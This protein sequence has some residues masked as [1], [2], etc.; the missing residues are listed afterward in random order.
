MLD[1]AYC[2]QCG[3]GTRA[4]AVVNLASGAILTFCRSHL[5]QH[6]ARLE[7]DNAYIIESEE[8]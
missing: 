2:D 8:D 5:N 6:R 7:A 1:G 3:P 4:K